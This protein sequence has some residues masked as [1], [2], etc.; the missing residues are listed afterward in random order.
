MD[1]LYIQLGIWYRR[2]RIVAEREQ[3]GHGKNRIFLK[4]LLSIPIDR[5]SVSPATVRSIVRPLKEGHLV[6]IFP[7]GVL[8]TEPYSLLPFKNGPALFAH[9][10][11]VPLIPVYIDRGKH[12]WNRLRFVFGD[13]LTIADRETISAEKG[14]ESYKEAL[15]LITDILKERMEDLASYAKSIRKE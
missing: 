13:P 10:G 1:V 7:E 3:L 6:D 9:M 14:A 11:G 12:F 4:L 5:D 15:P 2:H 8:N